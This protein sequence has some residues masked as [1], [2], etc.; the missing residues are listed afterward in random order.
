M[1]VRPHRSDI[2][3]LSMKETPMMNTTTLKVELKRTQDRCDE[4]ARELAEM[5]EK[6]QATGRQAAIERAEAARA[7]DAGDTLL[8]TA[9][10]LDLDELRKREQA[11]PLELWAVRVQVAEV[12]RD[13]LQADLEENEI[14]SRKAANEDAHAARIAAEAES[15]RQATALRSS[16]LAGHSQTLRNQL[17]KANASLTDLENAA[18]GMG[19]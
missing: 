6:I 17:R 13:L 16:D 12:S 11:L 1:T 15:T 9:A 8:A 3:T 7:G 4:L 19:A 5:P 14:E 10:D 2:L 18:P